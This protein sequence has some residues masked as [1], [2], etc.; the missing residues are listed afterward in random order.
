M[1]SRPCRR[2]VRVN[3]GDPNSA[4]DMYTTGREASAERPKVPAGPGRSTGVPSGTSARLPLHAVPVMRVVITRRLV[5][6]GGE[7]MEDSRR[8]PSASVSGGG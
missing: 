5:F 6:W 7:A 4:R 2:T 3:E 1:E 8:L